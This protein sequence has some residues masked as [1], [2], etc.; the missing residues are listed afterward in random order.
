MRIN[1]EITLKKN[2][3]PFD[4]RKGFI[5]L[6]KKA[7]EFE[8][9]ILLDKYYKNKMQKPFTFSVYFPGLRGK[10]TEN[11]FYVGEKAILNFSSNN[12]DLVVAIRNGMRK[13]KSFPLFYNEATYI[14]SF[15]DRNVKIQT[16]KARFKTKSP[17]LVNMKGNNL[18]Y[19]IPGE[20]EFNEAFAFNLKTTARNFL[21]IN[22]LEYELTPVFWKR[23]VVTHYNQNMSGVQGE[24]IL[25]TRPEVLQ[26]IY[27]IGFGVRRSQGF[28]ML[29]IINRYE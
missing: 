28:G 25:E 6:I 10:S 15:L 13:I 18:K 3:L 1:F 19:L 26:L 8:D 27:D 23:K 12:P 9:R 22:D 20:D 5:S 21:G 24:F 2:E 29:D 14:S 16:G 7:L 11:D 4:Y 17:L